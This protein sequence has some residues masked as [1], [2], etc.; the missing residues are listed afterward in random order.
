MARRTGRPSYQL[1]KASASS[2]HSALRGRGGRDRAGHRVAGWVGRLP[3][4]PSGRDRGDHREHQAGRGEAGRPADRGADRDGPTRSRPGRPGPDR[5][6]D[7][8]DRRGRAPDP[9]K[10]RQW[11]EVMRQAAEPFADPPSGTTA[12]NVARG[13]LR[14]A[15]QQ[16]SLAV[17]AYALAAGVP[18]AQRAALLDVT[19]RQAAEA[20]TIW[21]VAATQL[22]QISVDC[23]PGPPARVPGHRPA[24]R[25]PHPGRGGGGNRRLRH[26]A[27]QV[28]G[29]PAE[30][31]GAA[32]RPSGHGVI[33]GRRAGS[34]T[35]A[36][37]KVYE[38]DRLS[39]QWK[40]NR[41]DTAVRFPSA[42]RQAGLVVAVAA[43][44]LS[45]GL[46]EEGRQ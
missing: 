36:Y 20:A 7:G 5:H 39:M 27:A 12:T 43:L 45:S 29:L 18:A 14:G 1:D 41:R 23:R 26:F 2:A 13:G 37:R 46:R 34:G 40:P 33:W 3:G 6:Q 32:R 16:A 42:V 10:A 19:A 22:D 38:P 30:V 21:S 24:R 17:D 15:V 35:V 44:A 11:Q 8:D 9:A 28:S 25:G 31:A 4:G